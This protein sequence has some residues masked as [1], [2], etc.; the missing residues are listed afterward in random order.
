LR[1]GRSSLLGL[2]L[3]T[4]A[5]EVGAVDIAEVSYEGRPH[6]MVR[7]ER[8][9]WL[10]D[11]D[12]G[13]FSRLIDRD[14]RDWISF[15]AEPLDSFPESAAAGYRGL[16]N[17]VFVGPDKGAGHPGFDRC[18]SEVLGAD[19][20]R[21]TSLSGFWAWSWFFTE[22]T[23]TFT[24]ERADP[25]HPWWFL[26]EGPIAGTFEP[27]RKL[28]GTDE[29]DP[30]DEVPAIDSQ[31]FG[32]WRWVFFG[33]R[34]VP[35]VLFLAQ[36]EPDDRDDTVW[37]LGSSDGGAATA[38]EGMVVFGFGRGPDATPLLRGAG[39]RVTVGLLEIDPD[40]RPAIG[41]G[42]EAALGGRLEPPDQD[43]TLEIW[44]GPE[45]RFGHRGEPQRWVNVLGRVGGSGAL[46]SLAYELN[47]E[48]PA[49]L[50]VGT[51]LHRLGLPGDFNV[52]L[53]WDELRLGRNGL[54]VLARWQDGGRATAL[55]HLDVRRGRSWPLPF[56]VDL[57]RLGHLQD[58]VQVVDGEWR[59]TDDGVRTSS[60]WY[61][62]VLAVGDGSWRDYEATVLVTLHG[63]TPAQRGPP[64]YRVP[65]VG[66]TLRWPGHSPDGRQPSRQWYPL[67]AATEFLIQT[68]GGTGR[69]RILPDGGPRFAEVR[70]PEVSSLAPD[71]RF[72]L[73]ARVTTLPDGRSRYQ[74]KQWND[75]TPEPPGWAVESREGAGSDLASGSLLVVAHNTDVTVHEIRVEPVE[76]EER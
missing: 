54:R 39:V 34:G 61:D 27:G 45:Q 30:H 35:R 43:R 25:E 7:T 74:V 41:A 58:V 3:L 2:A 72:R 24:M 46:E 66:L 28:W 33:D 40:D 36:H 56:R 42:V 75:G 65:H 17:L 71:R 13:G 51:D 11:R 5:S 63:F 62:R 8:A 55:V 60:P 22:T 29:G 9:T 16:P 73:K 38:S 69:W 6:L 47:D 67:G 49:P 53:A 31:R 21:T 10:Y 4:L 57:A 70:A 12:G 59:L 23:A 32:R 48:G 50:A 14:G 15:G 1:I 20:I 52:E 44:Y 64:T 76:P 68:D 26:Y 19:T 18:T 37:F